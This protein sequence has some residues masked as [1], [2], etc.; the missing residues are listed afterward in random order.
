LIA[1][2]G[3]AAPETGQAYARARELCVA[4]AVDGTPS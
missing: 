4:P 1:V 2:K 3:N